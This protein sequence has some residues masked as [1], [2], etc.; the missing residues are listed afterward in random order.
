M[1]ASSCR[2]SPR[3]T[4]PNPITNRYLTEDGRL[5]QLVM[6][7]AT[8]FWPELLTAIGHPELAADDRFATPEG[9]REHS[10]EATR[11]LDEIFATRTLAQW[12]VA[13][14]DVKGVWAPVQTA[15]ELHD[16]PDAIANGYLAEVAAPNGTAFKLVASPVQFDEQPNELTARPST[17][18]TPTRCSSS[19][20]STGTSSSA[21]RPTTRSCSDQRHFHSGSRL[22]RN[23]RFA[24][25]ASSKRRRRAV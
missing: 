17:A 4:L 10:A 18:S 16:D 13:L 9:M 1:R 7:Q 15:I 19:S 3:E 23:A 20:A 22:S 5:L 2:S 25:L 24:S 21:S 14:R 6:L 8:R 11:L 12:K